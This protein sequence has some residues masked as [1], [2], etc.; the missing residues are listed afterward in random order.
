MANVPIAQWGDQEGI[1]P[2]WRLKFKQTI[3]EVP[4][5]ID[6]VRHADRERKLSGS[7]FIRILT[8]GGFCMA[9]SQNWTSVSS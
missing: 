9:L 3:G 1:G 8:T 5:G 6:G 7:D 4:T 2:E